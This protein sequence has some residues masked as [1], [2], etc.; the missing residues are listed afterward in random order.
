MLARRHRLPLPT[1]A[2]GVGRAAVVAY[3]VGRLGC[4]LAGDGTCGP[5]TDL[6]W[7]MSFPNGLVPTTVPVHPTP[8]YEALAAFVI[9]AVLWRVRTACAR[10]PRPGCT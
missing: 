2:G 6:P 5:P 8:L 1:A 3:G 7:G 10:P 9:A 4:L